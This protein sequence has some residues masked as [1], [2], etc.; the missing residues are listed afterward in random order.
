MRV[1]CGSVVLAGL[2]AFVA[3][4]NS[5]AECGID[6]DCVDLEWRPMYQNV[7]G[8]D[9]VEIGLYAVPSDGVSTVSMSVIQVVL[10]WNPASLTLLNIKNNGPYVW[11]VSALPNEPCGLNDTWTDGDAL[12]L[13]MAQLVGDPPFATPEGL[14]VTTF[15]FQATSETLAN[16]LDIVATGNPQCDSVVLHGKIPSL[17]ISGDLGFARVRVTDT[18]YT[19]GDGNSDQMIDLFDFELFQACVTGPNGGLL[20]DCHFFDFDLDLDVDL[21]DFYWFELAFDQ[22]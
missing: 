1:P 9:I 17:D 2:L 20:P 13:A 11:F 19:P 10:E 12:Y 18:P 6:F 7:V 5:F 15:R 16:Q 3:S 8:G 22:P 21:I 14:L 4:S